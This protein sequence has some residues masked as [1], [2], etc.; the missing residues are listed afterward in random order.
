MDDVLL[1]DFRRQWNDTSS[2]VMAAVAAV[3]ESGHYILGKE[4]ER[5][6]DAL[7]RVFGRRHAIGCA[8]GLDAIELSLRA[9]GVKP[10]TKVLTTPLSAFATTLAILRAGAV[11]VFVDVDAHG[12]IDLA[13]CREVLDADRAI[14]AIVPVHLYGHALDL[15]ALEDLGR[16][17]DLV[18]V[19]D[20]AQS[21][22]AAFRGRKAGTV[23][24]LAATSFYPTKNLGALGDG[25]AI[26]C[27]D[28]ALAA[29]CRSLRDYGQ[30]RKYVHDALGL[31]SRLDELHAAVLARAFLPR[32]EGW[33]ERRRRV[34]EA[35]DEGLR[36][37][38]VR[39]VGAPAGSES[40][41]HL[42]PVVVRDG[43]REAFLRH[44]SSR[45]V[46]AAVHYPHL[47]PSQK[48]LA[49]TPFEVKGPLTR[50]EEFAAGEVSLPIHPYLGDE[51]V[52][53]VVEAVCGWSGA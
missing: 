30:S 25:G 41:W 34:A 50:A 5:F 29:R 40:V 8:S 6:E 12:L 42:Y 4:V 33:T 38:R 35:Y 47:I 39:V 36:N 13:R 51:E 21:I 22:G 27:D 15:G 24:G 37:P 32:L 44:L 52:R 18:V 45:G 9:S 48:A 1:N 26:T 19:E 28:E 20:C 10:G 3:G 2:E 49:G 43:G 17:Y 14:R 23:G 46:R 7:A 16:R 11:P 53:R 31:N